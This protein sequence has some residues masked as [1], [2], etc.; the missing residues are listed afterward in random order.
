MFLKSE[1]YKII[2]SKRS[3]FFILLIFV[4]PCIDLIINIYYQYGD[5]WMN[6]EAYG[7]ELL[8][9]EIVA[10]SIASFLTGS[11]QGHIMQMLFAWIL[12]MYIMLIYGQFYIEERK[13]GYNSIIFTKMNRVKIIKTKFLTAFLVPFTISLISL[14]FNFICA[15]LFFHGGENFNGLE[16]LADVSK[17]S[18]FVFSHPNF[19][20]V[21]YIIVFA[22]ITGAY[23][24]VCTGISFLFPD[25][26]IA[27]AVTF[28]VWIVQI[29]YHYSLTYAMQPF[30]EYG[31]EYFIPSLAIYAF[32][33]VVVIVMASRYKVKYDEL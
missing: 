16:S 19:A 31:P 18:M 14:F 21:G 8:K 26:K 12:P 29:I 3:M 2:K 11:N 32:I 10:P 15:Q 20:Y 1:L 5:F 28:I 25:Y 33:V 30:I 7:G 4:L 24:V 27:Y 13:C 22:M 6:K 17:F 9:G 23:G